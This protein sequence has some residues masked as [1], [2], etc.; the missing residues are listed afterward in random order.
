MISERLVIISLEN[1]GGT[2]IARDK[3]SSLETVAKN[4]DFVP[5]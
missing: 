1:S 3:K 5:L 4:H 2:S